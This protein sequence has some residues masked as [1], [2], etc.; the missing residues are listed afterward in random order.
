MSRKIFGV[1]GLFLMVFSG[2]GLYSTLKPAPKVIEPPSVS[3]FTVSHD[4]PVEGPVSAVIDGRTIT[5]DNLEKNR[6]FIPSLKVYAPIDESGSFGKVLEGELKLPE[7]TKVTRWR[8]GAKV[9]ASKGATMLAGHVNEGATQGA[10]FEL[11]TVRPGSL[12]FVTDSSGRTRSFKLVAIEN[13]P[14][15]KTA[16]IDRLWTLTGPRR[17]YVLTCTGELHVT[18]NGSR[19]FG[20]NLVTEWV[21]NV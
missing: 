21:P 6:L 12:A 15:S 5:A 8:P 2:W 17:L 14:K 4:T 16:S 13:V 20:S 10:L 19:S 11:A 18:A 1:L 7:A 9:T 3:N